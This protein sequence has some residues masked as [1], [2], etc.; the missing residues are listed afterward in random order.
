MQR[1]LILEKGGGYDGQFFYFEAYDPFLRRFASHPAAYRTFIDAPPYRFGRIG[2]VW[3]TT[4]FSLD[5]WQAYPRTMVWLVFA[6]I[7]ACSLILGV[8]AKDA[9]LSPALGGLVILIPGF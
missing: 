2:Y 9:G 8:V 1:S 7:V 5:N 4:A 3:L 6:A